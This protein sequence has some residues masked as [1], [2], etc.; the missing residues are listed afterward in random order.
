MT[1]DVFVTTTCY[2]FYVTQ[3]SNHAFGGQPGRCAFCSIHSSL[4]LGWT[5]MERDMLTCLLWWS[6]RA[7]LLVAAL[8]RQAEFCSVQRLKRPRSCSFF[9]V[10]QLIT[11]NIVLFIFQVLHINRRFASA[12]LQHTAVSDWHFLRRCIFQHSRNE[13]PRT[14]QSPL[15]RP[16]RSEPFP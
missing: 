2:R 9:L 15:Q 13:I 5:M 3:K 10:H 14:T 6:Y 8:S 1:I 12:A 7:A 11:Y 4:S 16:P